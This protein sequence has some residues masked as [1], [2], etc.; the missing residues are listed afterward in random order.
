MPADPCATGQ[1]LLL[2][3]IGVQWLNPPEHA[4]RCLCGQI[5][6]QPPPLL[7]SRMTTTLIEIVP[8]STSLCRCGAALLGIMRLMYAIAR[9]HQ[10]LTG[11]TEYSFSPPTAIGLKHYV[12]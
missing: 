9:V 7:G 2:G 10:Q 4:S 12:R 6:D 3:D 5:L 8:I 1:L 11:V